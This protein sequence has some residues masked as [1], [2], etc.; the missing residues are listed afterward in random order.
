MPNNMLSNIGSL[1]TEAG[2]LK[3]LGAFSSFGAIV[4][5]WNLPGSL[6]S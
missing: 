2:N 3:Y 6:A 4:A 1:E 5:S